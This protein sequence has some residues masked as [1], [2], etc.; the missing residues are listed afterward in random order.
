MWPTT[1]D[2]DDNNNKA[3]MYLRLVERLHAAMADPPC[4]PN[5]NSTAMASRL[6]SSSLCNV[7]SDRPK[8]SGGP[9]LSW[10]DVMK[11]TSRM[12]VVLPEFNRA[13][14]NAVICS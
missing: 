10:I 14:C 4:A 11:P 5:P 8:L 1:D 9:H 2:D 3:G 13:F 6:P 12:Y 7:L